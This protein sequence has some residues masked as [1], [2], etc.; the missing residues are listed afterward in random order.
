MSV[1]KKPASILDSIVRLGDYE[2]GRPTSAA[3]DGRPFFDADPKRPAGSFTI[4]GGKSIPFFEE[5]IAEGPARFATIIGRRVVD[6]VEEIY[7]PLK[8]QIEALQAAP[9]RLAIVTAISG[10]KVSIIAAGQRV[11]VEPPPSLE[12]KVGDA[13][14][15]TVDTMQILRHAKATPEGGTVLTIKRVVDG[16]G[17]VETGGIARA[18]CLPFEA[19]AGDRVVV[20]DSATVAV[21]N[22]GP[23]PSTNVVSEATGVTWDD[24]GG[25]ATAKRLMREAVEEPFT[26]AEAFKRWGKKPTKGVLLSGPPGCGKTMLG[27]AAA[28]A[29]ADAHGSGS[30]GFFY[31]KG[32][33]LLNS[34]VGASEANVRKLF[35]DARRHKA[36]AGF[37]AVIFL[38]EADAILGKRGGE[39]TIGMERTIVPQ[40]L[41]EMDG[42]GDSGAIVILATNRPEALD[43]AIVRDGRIDRRVAVTRPEIDDVVDIATRLFQKCPRRGSAAR[44]ARI[45]AARYS[46][47][48]FRVLTV[49][50]VHGEEIH[51][52][53]WAGRCGASVAGIVERAKSY[54]MR[55]GLS[56]VNRESVEVAVRELYAESLAVDHDDEIREV[57]GPGPFLRIERRTA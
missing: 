52:S 49:T 43:P 54:A 11:E 31:V 14:I 19:A 12:I 21:R 15:V 41:A 40:F 1:P 38:D 27:K 20:D 5:E 17:E 46:S 48:L 47:P 44:L 56:G 10:G 53:L 33:E 32:P 18:I 35:E 9:A 13:V 2:Y 4:P 30:G 37:P 50:N 28:T 55:S 25:L 3:Y 51:V 39:R 57:C 24:I 7:A 36:R 6:S 8:K 45:L 34:F 22:L 16:L 29:L 26:N 42:V 23:D